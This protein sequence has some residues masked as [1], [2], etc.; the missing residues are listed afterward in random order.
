MGEYTIHSL[1]PLKY[2]YELESN[3]LNNRFTADSNIPEVL[4]L[5]R[6]KTPYPI[7]TKANTSLCYLLPADNI[8]PKVQQYRLLWLYLIGF[9]FLGLLLHSIA[10]QILQSKKA[11]WSAAFLIISVFWNSPD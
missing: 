10:K 8:F 5:V 7:Q 2:S 3:Y 11:W 6:T 1:I 4:E 9:F